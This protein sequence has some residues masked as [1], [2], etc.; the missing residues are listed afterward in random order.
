MGKFIR[1]LTS[2]E[3]FSR[4]QFI[5]FTGWHKFVTRRNKKKHRLAGTIGAMLLKKEKNI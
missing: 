4:R 2:R 5:L 1:K 3:D